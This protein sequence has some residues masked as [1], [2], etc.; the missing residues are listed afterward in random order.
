M[1]SSLRASRNGGRVAF[2]HALFAQAQSLL[3]K[4]SIYLLDKNVEFLGVL[5]CSGLPAQFEPEFFFHGA[6]LRKSGEAGRLQ[7]LYSRMTYKTL[8]NLSVFLQHYLYRII[9]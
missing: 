9:A 5:L 3:F 6:R 8:G 2:G 4:D 1:Q 7:T